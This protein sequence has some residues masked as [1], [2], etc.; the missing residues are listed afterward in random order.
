MALAPEEPHGYSLGLTFDACDSS[1]AECDGRDGALPER[2]RQ[3]DRI[4][5]R[6]L[7]PSGATEDWTF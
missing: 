4:C 3:Y 5:Y 7:P 6:H 2:K 1:G